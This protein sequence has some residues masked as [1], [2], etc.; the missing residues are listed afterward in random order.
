MS[1][2]QKDNGYPSLIGW[3][4]Y[5]YWMLR[6]W[7]ESRRPDGSRGMYGKLVHVS[8]QESM[9]FGIIVSDRCGRMFGHGT[10]IL[11]GDGKIQIGGCYCPVTYPV[12]N[13]DESS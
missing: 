13:Q 12:D 4:K 10:V 2:I 9:Q 1:K 7:F 6:G 5:K 11:R 3:I 8:V